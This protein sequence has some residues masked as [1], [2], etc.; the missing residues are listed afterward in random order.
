MPMSPAPPGPPTES[1][2]VYRRQASPR[3]GQPQARGRRRCCVLTD[4]TGRLPRNSRQP[5][6][7]AQRRW[8]RSR[9]GVRYR[10]TGPGLDAVAAANARTV[11]ATAS[12]R[13]G[14]RA[15]LIAVMTGLTES[16]LRVLSNPKRPCRQPVPERGRGLRPR[17][18]RDLPAA[19]ELWHCGPADGPGHVDRAVPGSA[20]LAAGLALARSPNKR[21]PCSCLLG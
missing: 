4:R 1:D 21:A 14:R 18:A 13:G 9:I 19:P 6:R 20:A 7:L 16:G 2:L 3:H 15:A 17:L 11:A 12:S 5:R 10:R 8:V